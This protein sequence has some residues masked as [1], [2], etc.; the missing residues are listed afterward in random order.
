MSIERAWRRPG[1]F[2]IVGIL[3]CSVPAFAQVTFTVTKTADTNDGTCDAD[4]SLREAIAAANPNPAA[5]TV[6]I[7]AGTY[8]LTI[9]GAHEDA[10]ATGDLDITDALTI[11]GAGAATTIVNGGGIDRVFHIVSDLIVQ[12]NNIT[13]S[14]GV[15]TGG[16]SGGGLLSEGVVTLNNCIVSGNSAPNANGGGVYSDN[17]FTIAG[18]T[19]TGNTA[20][21]GDGGGVYDNG[22]SGNINTST[23]SGNSVPGGDGGGL[24]FN[25][26]STQVNQCTFTGNHAV[27]G[28]G[29]G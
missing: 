22:V 3:L 5:A 14:G 10:N 8:T 27:G 2:L 18:S 15:T 25:G 16:D 1:L 6:A 13:I 7:P 12:I 28:D 9:A 26:V 29:A 17:V 4:C 21:N 19:I 24:Y 23:F 11:N 20:A